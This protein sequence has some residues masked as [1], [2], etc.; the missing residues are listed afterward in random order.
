[1]HVIY[2]SPNLPD[3]RGI[4]RFGRK[5]NTQWILS[6]FSALENVLPLVSIEA[7]LPLR[8]IYRFVEFETD[9]DLQTT[10]GAG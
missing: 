7:E 4:H 10:V 6:E 9:A 1:M 3:P 2:H 8:Q 5:G